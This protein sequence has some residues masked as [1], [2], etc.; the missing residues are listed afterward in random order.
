MSLFK[1]NKL[2]FNYSRFTF[3]I[4]NNNTLKDTIFIP[5]DRLNYNFSRS[6]GPGGQNV[7]KLN[8]KVEIRLNIDTID[9]LCEE[10]KTNLKEICKNQ[11]N[12]Q[13]EL[14]IICQ[15]HRTQSQNKKEAQHKLKDF[16]EKASQ[17]K[18]ERVTGPII[19]PPHKK[20]SRLK[21]KK[22]RSD[23]KKLRNDTKF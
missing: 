13:G 17:E 10:V 9:W 20:E 7:N 3:S 2:L 21:E 8:S 19:E 12:N 11:I 6:S 22:M 23:I 14:L 16:I 18:N 4:N 15:E 5:F 1:F